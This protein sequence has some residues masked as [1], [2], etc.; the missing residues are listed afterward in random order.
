M[1]LDQVDVSHGQ[2][3]RSAIETLTATV[4]HL[5]A[6]VVQCFNEGKVIAPLRMQSIVSFNSDLSSTSLGKKRSHVNSEL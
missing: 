6:S 5:P 4:Y 3:V 1:W 2:K